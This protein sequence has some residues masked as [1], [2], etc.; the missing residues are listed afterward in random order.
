MD[1]NKKIKE[2]EK[3]INE[4]KAERNREILEMRKNGKTLMDI[5]DFFGI[6]NEAVRL[7]LLNIKGVDKLE[8]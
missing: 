7:I 5:G 8:K 6:S 4:L 1:Y 3:E 2:L